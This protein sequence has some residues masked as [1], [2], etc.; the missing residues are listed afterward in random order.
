MSQG[1]VANSS[2]RRLKPEEYQ[3]LLSL[4]ISL[5]IP[6]LHTIVVHAGILPMDPRRKI[7]SPRQPLSHLPK[8]DNQTEPVLRNLQELALFTDI[9]QNTNPWAKMNMRS[10]LNNG[11][12]SKDK[13]GLPWSDLWHKVIK[14]CDG[15]DVQLTGNSTAAEFTAEDGWPEWVENDFKGVKSLPCKDVTVVYGHAASRG[16]DIK[17]WSKGLD[18]GCVYNLQLTAL[19]LGKPWKAGSSSVN[20]TVADEDMYQVDEELD[21]EVVE[22]G[23]KGRGMIV[24]VRCTGG[25][26]R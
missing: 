26:G 10:I 20:A 11:K 6:S 24:Q 1:I 2:L 9:P 17:K 19:V 12:V 8:S 25:A 13:D 23:K 4:P 18:T 16:L 7:V 3:Y 15:F 5:H 22:F 14:L 21:G